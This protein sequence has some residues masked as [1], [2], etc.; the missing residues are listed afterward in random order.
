MM[1]LHKWRRGSSHLFNYLGGEV[2]AKQLDLDEEKTKHSVVVVDD[3]RTELV[4]LVLPNPSLQN[5]PSYL[6]CRKVLP[7]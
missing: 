2:A 7:H 6:F 3:A 4:K 1:K 5:P